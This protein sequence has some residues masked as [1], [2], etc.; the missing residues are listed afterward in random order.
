MILI[1][2]HTNTHVLA[3]RFSQSLLLGPVRL[4]V[5]ERKPACALV[6]LVVPARHGSVAGKH[7]AVQSKGR[8]DS[9]ADT[10]KKEAC[11]ARPGEAAVAVEGTRYV[12]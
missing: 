1:L 2:H 7:N 11:L 10:A 12:V 5:L 4:R 9:A 8:K 3:T 6:K